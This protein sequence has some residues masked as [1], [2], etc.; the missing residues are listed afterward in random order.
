[1]GA[2]ISGERGEGRRGQPDGT[3]RVAARA[4]ARDHAQPAVKP[5]DR[6]PVWTPER[7]LSEVVGDGGQPELAGAALPGTLPGQ[8]TKDPRRLG[9]AA[10]A[11]GQHS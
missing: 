1:M 5:L 3:V 4:T 9:D 2:Q 6:V 11:R 10:T 8:V 7:E